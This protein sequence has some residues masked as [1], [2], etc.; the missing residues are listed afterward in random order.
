MNYFQF[1]AL[2]VFILI[3]VIVTFLSQRKNIAL[4]RRRDNLVK[5][6]N[7]VVRL[8]S[9]IP[10]DALTPRFKNACLEAQK[11]LSAREIQKDKK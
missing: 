11:L 5:S 9:D 2:S 1:I 4:R 8:S 10:N 7:D 3:C 6:L